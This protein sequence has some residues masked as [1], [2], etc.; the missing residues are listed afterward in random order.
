MFKSWKNPL[1]IL[2]ELDI[3][4]ST[5]QTLKL[6]TS[7]NRDIQ[8]NGVLYSTSLMAESK[9]S[10]LYINSTFETIIVL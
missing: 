10:V 1:Y 6:S 7:L 9:V 5:E 3:F 2:L 4:P 8:D